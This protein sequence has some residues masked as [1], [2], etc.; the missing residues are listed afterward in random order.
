MLESS[1]SSDDD[2]KGPSKASVPIFKGPSVQGLLDY[3][4]YNDIEE[5]LS[6]NY[7]PSTYKENTDKDISDKNTTDEDYIH[8]CNYAM[9]KACFCICMQAFPS[10][11]LQVSICKQSFAACIC[12]LHLQL[13]F[14][15]CICKQAFVATICSL[16]LQASICSLLF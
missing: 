11:H 5:Y 9:S 14:A 7:F 8:E 4:G 16:H 12:S 2:T 3:Y 6:W 10:K 15:A 13:A 1:D